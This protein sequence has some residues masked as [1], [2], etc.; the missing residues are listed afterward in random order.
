[1]AA[2]WLTMFMTSTMPIIQIVLMCCM[3]ALLARQVCRSLLVIWWQF[4]IEQ[5]LSRSWTYNAQHVGRRVAGHPAWSSQATPW[6]TCVL[7]IRSLSDFH[8]ACIRCRPEQSESLVAPTSQHSIEVRHS[9]PVYQ[10]AYV[11]LANMFAHW[12]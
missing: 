1:M 4:A 2:V 6:T 11:F 9:R 8:Q 5:E 3:G 7:Y 12:S 10:I